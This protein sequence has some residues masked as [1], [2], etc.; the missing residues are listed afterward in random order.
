MFLLRLF[1]Q[2]GVGV[3][4]HSNSL[5]CA[6]GLLKVPHSTLLWDRELVPVGPGYFKTPLG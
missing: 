2:F 1:L 5:A 4:S 3:R 6:V